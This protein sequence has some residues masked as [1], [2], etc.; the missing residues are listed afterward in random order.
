MTTRSTDRGGRRAALLRRPTAPERAS[1]AGRLPP[2]ASPRVRHALV[3]LLVVAAALAGAGGALFVVQV[4]RELSVGTVRF[5]VQP[6]HPGALDVYVPVVDWGMRF[7]GVRLPV[8]LSVDVRSID[9]D[10]VADLA[11]GGAF[12]VVAVRE[13]AT[14]A[15]RSF[16]GVLLAVMLLGGLVLGGL[17][18]LALRSRRGPRLR[19]ALAVAVLTTV[20]ATTAV[21]LLLPPRLSASPR[22]EYYA[23]GAD[24]PRA[25]EIVRT[26]R[27]SADRLD[28]ELD[29]Q[30]VG[31]ARLVIAPAGRPPLD[32]LPRLTIAS[33]L[34]NNVLALPALERAAARGPLL[35]AGDLT[36]AGSRLEADLVA[37]VSRTGRPLVF[38]SGNHDSDTLERRLAGAGAVVLSRRGRLRPGRAP[39]PVVARVGGLRMAGYEDP[40]ERRA[41]QRYRD[42]GA[43][44][45]VDEQ[46]AFAAWLGGLRGR[47]DVVLLHNP[48][49]AAQALAE[50]EAHPPPSPLVLVTGHT[51]RAAVDRRGPVTV[52]NGGTVGGGGATNVEDGA[53]I[54]VAALTYRTRG[55]AFAPLAA[56]LIEIDPGDG[57]ATARRERLDAP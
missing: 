41:A 13:E 29:E 51:H 22:P 9:R 57:S 2:S 19:F 49:L 47:V 1:R 6:G 25:L 33:D 20:A 42:R 32:G 11:G 21:A 56:D 39:G 35:F 28:A 31:L 18:A 52:V 16:F 44:V 54:G 10:A 50:L 12:D 24:I 30:L 17:V 4:D 14:R 36:D 37:R 40:R 43:T 34:H 15:A 26:L 55:G 27:G 53:A 38:V 7:G 5:A 23:N 46:E 3:L 45:T 8:R 48:G